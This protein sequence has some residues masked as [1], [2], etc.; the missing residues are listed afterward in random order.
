M[1]FVLSRKAKKKTMRE[2]ILERLTP[3]FQEVFN[4]NVVVIETLDASQVEEWD[5][6]NHIALIIAIEEEFGLEFS[7]DEIAQMQ[8][9]GDLVDI[10][11]RRNAV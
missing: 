6:L 1:G 9:V 10:L 7:T 4:P 8:K 11:V 3:I 5:S 2:K